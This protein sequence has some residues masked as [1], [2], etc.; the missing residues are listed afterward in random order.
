MYHPEQKPRVRY[1]AQQLEKHAGPVVAATDYVK[2]F[3]DQVREFVPRRFTALGT[4]GF[5]RSDTRE[6]LRHFFEVDRRYVVVAA[7]KAL[8]DDGELDAKKVGE[9]IKKYK[10]NPDKPNPV[11]V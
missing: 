5:G 4:D 1:I 3:A 10:L 6:G 8:A 7:L 2:L 9:A 11:T